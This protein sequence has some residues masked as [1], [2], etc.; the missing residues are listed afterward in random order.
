MNQSTPTELTHET[1]IS[2]FLDN[3]K[4]EFTHDILRSLICE[5]GNTQDCE[6]RYKTPIRQ[7]LGYMKIEF[8]EAPSQVPY[9]FRLMF[10]GIEYLVEVKK[11]D[12]PVSKLND[13]YPKEDSHYIFLYTA[14][15]KSHTPGV[16]Y[17]KGCD[18][19][20]REFHNTRKEMIDFHRK[21]SKSPT[22]MSSVY[23]RLNISIDSSFLVPLLEQ[24]GYIPLQNNKELLQIIL[25]K[26]KA[27]E[28]RQIALK[29]DIDIYNGFTK[30][31][32]PRYKPMVTIRQKL[33][34]LDDRSIECI[35]ED[36]SHEEPSH[37]EPSHE[38]PS[39]EELFHE[40]PYIKTIR[41]K[42]LQNPEFAKNWR[43]D[44]M[45]LYNALN[46]ALK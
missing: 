33:L 27:Y 41:D 40:E 38:E 32:N 29:Y 20:D 13:T 37:E 10:K 25:N 6:N 21:C 3:I 15:N 45:T 39:H 16:L 35:I 36:T 46:G 18:F 23:P 22:T 14:K 1:L 7:I 17:V 12:T 8:D 44:E 11:L 24:E 9:D 5:K 2:V 42:L 43:G 31:G 19:P 4:K 34:E 26:L 30:K 28:L